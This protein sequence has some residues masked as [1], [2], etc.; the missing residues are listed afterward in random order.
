MSKIYALRKSKY[1]TQKDLADLLNID[2]TTVSH[3]ERGKSTPDTLN[4]LK[5]ANLF[6]VTLDYL[7]GRDENKKSKIELNYDKIVEYAAVKGLMPEDIK[8]LID[9]AVSIREKR[10]VE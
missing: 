10:L 8:N 9:F 7:T 1:L 3:W 5:L 4:L 6:N 2:Q